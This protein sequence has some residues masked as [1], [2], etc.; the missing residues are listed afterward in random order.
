M[1]IDLEK[2]NIILA[3]DCGST[4]TKAI[5]IQKIDGVYRQTHRGEAPSTVEE[6]FADVT[7]GVVNSVTEVSDLAGRRLIDGNGKIILP[8]NGAEGSDLYIS[9]SSAGGGLQMM[10]AGVIAEMT[11]ASAKRA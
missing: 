10:V 1:T 5:L 8:S 11:A 4:T 9:T 2:I 6:P 7:V 3:T